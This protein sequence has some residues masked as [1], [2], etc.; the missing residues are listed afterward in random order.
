M[1]KT[2]YFYLV[3]TMLF[4]FLSCSPEVS[5]PQPESPKEYSYTVNITNASDFSGCTFEYIFYVDSEK[6]DVKTTVDSSVTFKTSKE[7]SVKVDITAKNSSGKVIGNRIG[8]TCYSMTS[9]LLPFEEVAVLES[10]SVSASELYVYEAEA[11][12]EPK[13]VNLKVMAKYSDGSNKD[14][15]TTAFYTSTDTSIL[16]VSNSGVVTGVKKGI[17]AVKVTYTYEGVTKEDSVNI[18]VLGEDDPIPTK[19][20]KS[21]ELSPK[22]VVL[23]IGDTASLNVTA[24]YEYE[25]KDG[26][27][28]LDV[29]SKAEYI[30]GDIKVVSVGNGV[31]TAMGGGTASIKVSYTESDITLT[32]TCEVVV[33]TLS[34][35]SFDNV[36]KIMALNSVE[37]V[38]LMAEFTDGTKVNIAEDASFSSSDSNIVS[39]SGG[40]FEAKAVGTATITATYS[41]GGVSKTAEIEITV[42]KDKVLDSIMLDVTGTENTY[43]LKVT[44]K[45]SDGSTKDVTSSSEITLSN[46]NI[47]TVSGGILT[48]KTNGK[49]VVSIEYTDGKTVSCKKE[50]EVKISAVT[51]SGITANLSVTS[52]EVGK[53]ADVTV[54]AAYSDGSTKDVTSEAKFVLNGTSATLSG[55]KITGI[56]AGKVSIVITFEDKE[57]TVSLTVKEV[58]NGYRVHFYGASWSTYKIYYYNSTKEVVSEWVSMPSM[59]SETDGCFYDLTESW[60]AAGK[61]MVIF[62]GGDNNNRYPADQVDGVV[63]PTGVNE[64]WFNFKSKRFETT[65]PFSTDPVVDL[66][67]SGSLEFYGAKQAVKLIATNCTTAKYT[68]DG[69]DPKTSGT[70]YT[71]GETISVGESLSIGQ[72]V[73]VKVWGTD[74]SME[75]TASATY[76]KSPK[77]TIPT[78]LGAYYTNASTSFSIWSPDSSNVTVTVTPKG[79]TAKEYTCTAGF[80]VDGGYPDTANIYGVTVSGD[81][82]LAEY[83]FKIGGKAVRD[84]YGVMVKYEDDDAK[85]NPIKKNYPE[86]NCT[87]SSYAGSSINIV[88]DVERISP[89]GGSWAARPALE[90]R[91]KSVVYEIHVGDFTSHSS[92]NGKPTNAGKF[93]GMV[94]TGTKYS[95]VSTGIDHLKE[96]G[97]THVQILPFY[98]FATKYNETIGEYYNWGYDPV[99]YNVPEERYSLTP[100]D[101]ENRIREVKDMVDILHQ[102]GIRVIMD[103][104]YNHTFD[105]EMFKNISNKY[106]TA[107]DLSGCGN[108]VD[109]TNSMVSRMVRDSLEY[110]LETYNLDGFRFDLMGIFSN[111]AIGE[112]GQYLNQKYSDRTLLLYGEPYQANNTNNTSYAYASSI[113]GLDYAKVGGFAHKYR[114]T[115][116]GGSDDGVKGYIFNATEK[117]GD[118]TVW[119]VQVGLKGSMTSIGSDTEGV[120]TRYFTKG[121]YQAIN[122]LAAHDNLCLYDKIVRSGIT[123]G[124]SAYQQGIVKF[125]HGIITLSQGVGFIHGGDDFLRT[126]SGDKWSEFKIDSRTA[127]ENSYMFGQGMNKIDWSLK[128]KYSDVFKYH[129]DLIAFKKSHDGFWN[130]SA[131]TRAEGMVIYYTVKDSNGKTLTCVLNPGNNINYSGSGNQVFNKKGIINSSDSDYSSKVCEGTGITIFEQ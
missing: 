8:K 128:V 130:G 106:Y 27:V 7:G 19:I 25:D 76:K 89:T 23:V 12:N 62:Y 90:N 64:A 86:S 24:C 52:L 120:W 54:S 105:G 119:N 85:T 84:P 70:V 61:T 57:T 124:N 66:S 127:K 117:D 4:S 31:I 102:N 53:T 41:A 36:T 17:C 49:V 79:G 116:K 29:T 22:S 74:G 112:W 108:S 109:V 37:D 60:V 77:P 71:D 59:K 122:Y 98:D 20:L 39:V 81:L 47:A 114:E 113:P 33:K 68:I 44:A 101:Y 97:V 125:G 104:V 28:K 73:T 21:I 111:S 26:E 75:S 2:S 131:S 93:A 83:Q 58:I 129:K 1:K 63:L 88:V 78:R 32:E 15:T 30:T 38:V 18:K 67:P 9:V 6:E 5:Q 110:W 40:F 91:A 43:T 72:S 51:L 14:V 56:S 48:A 46:E 10:I 99:N 34:S 65:N 3:L 13:T 121:S 115:L 126:K 87:V 42:T 100:K 11:V 95:G 103:V 55:T 96:L 80:K 16:T 118:G 45:Y 69:S 50:V 82:H 123:S 92:W 94:E 35:I 107:K